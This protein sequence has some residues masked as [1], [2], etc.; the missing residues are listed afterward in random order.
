MSIPVPK[1]PPG[2]VIGSRDAAVVLDLFIDYQCPHSKEAWPTML[3]LQ[4]MYEGSLCLVIHPIVG[5]GNRQSYHMNRMVYALS[6]TVEKFVKIS[7]ICF[8]TQENFSNDA[9]FHKSEIDLIELCAQ[10]AEEFDNAEKEA[11]LKIFNSKK[12]YLAAKTSIRESYKRAVWS[13]PS[14]F[15]NGTRE[16]EMESGSSTDDWVDKINGMM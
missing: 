7:S 13:T 10:Y 4:E 6:D 8:D 12:N 16:T 1:R 11:F 15:L 2:F 3:E 14:F 9:F 5:V